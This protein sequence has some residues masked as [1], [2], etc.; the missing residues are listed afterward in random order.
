MPVGV[1]LADE[2]LEKLYQLVEDVDVV[3]LTTRRLDGSLVSRPMA[4]Q[5]RAEGAHFWLVTS[6]EMPKVAEIERDPNVN[7][8][9]VRP[10]TGEWVSVSGVARTCRDPE[11]IRE[12]YEPAWKRW[13]TK[14]AGRKNGGPEDP[15]IV[16]IGVEARSAHLMTA[17]RT[18]PIVL[19]ENLPPLDSEEA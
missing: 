18:M 1:A 3:L 7:L 12:L 14:E 16:L 8:A 9:Y 2:R 13:F 19:F 10:R 6:R 17:Q 11:R 4:T 5:R 15:R